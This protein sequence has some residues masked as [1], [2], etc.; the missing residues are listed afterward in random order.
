MSL[1]LQRVALE[2][3]LMLVDTKYEFGKSSDGTIILIDE[4][5]NHSHEYISLL[6]LPLH[7]HTTHWQTDSIT[8]CNSRSIHLTQAGIGL[9]IHMKNAFRVVLNLKM[10][11]RCAANF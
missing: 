11:I 8:Y 7:A 9:P 6:S 5:R 2:H 3:G 1:K 4:V 10:L